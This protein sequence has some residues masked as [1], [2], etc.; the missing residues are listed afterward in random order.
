MEKSSQKENTEL[1]TKSKYPDWDRIVHI[2]VVESDD[3]SELV[4]DNSMLKLVIV[5]EGRVTVE[6][7]GIRKVV[8]APALICLSDE[9]VLFSEIID[10]NMTVVY[11]KSTEV[12][13]EF[14]M[15]R[16]H[17][18]EFEDEIGRTI[19]QDYLLIKG[20][21]SGENINNKIISINSSAHLKITKLVNTINNELEEQKDG[22]W[23]CRS[24]SFLMELLYSIK[25]LRA[26]GGRL[27][28]EDKTDSDTVGDI[29]QYLNEHIADK[30]TLENILKE[31]S[32]NRNQ[33]NGM[34]IKETSMTCLNYLEKMRINLSQLMLSETE[35]QIAEIAY[36]VGYSDP[37]Y[38][39][40]VFKKHTGVTPSKYR[41]NSV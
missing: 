4:S 25:F 13:E 33:L 22:Y 29:I 17:N 3:I 10:L 5:N 6:L 38:F 37:N 35:L 27:V 34:F 40:K 31:Y 26:D 19:Y 41:E 8:N 39:I 23:P 20:F 12:R 24:R 7:T 2:K 11:F 18:G 30:I 9:D 32:I 16:M 36:R 21:V 15:E 28:L 1:F 14:T